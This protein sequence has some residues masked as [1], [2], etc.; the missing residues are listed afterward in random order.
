MRDYYP[1]ILWVKS[2]SFLNGGINSRAL[3]GCTM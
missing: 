1:D 3:I 2:M